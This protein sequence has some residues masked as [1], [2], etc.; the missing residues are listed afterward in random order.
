MVKE[1]FLQAK[2]A[3]ERAAEIFKKSQAAKSAKLQK[4]FKRPKRVELQEHQ[5][6]DSDDWF[7]ILLKKKDFI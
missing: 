3:K 2:E 1:Q 4:K 6:S 7:N 5:L